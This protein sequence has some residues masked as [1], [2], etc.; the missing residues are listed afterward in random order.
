MDNSSKS[1]IQPLKSSEKVP[2]LEETTKLG[3]VTYQNSK[4]EYRKD[5]RNAL[6]KK[7]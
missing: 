1:Y 6:R 4:N 5:R 2:K 3:E 7:L